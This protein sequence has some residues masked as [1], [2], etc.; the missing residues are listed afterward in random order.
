[1]IVTVGETTVVHILADTLGALEVERRTRNIRHNA[2]G[3]KHVVNGSVFRRVYLHNMILDIAAALALEVEI[4][5]VGEVEYRILV[6]D[7][8]VTNAQSVFQQRKADLDLYRSREMLLAVG[9]CQPERYRGL[10]SVINTLDSP[11]ALVVAE[12]AA[13]Q[14]VSI[15]VHGELVFC[16]VQREFRAA[17]S[18]CVTS[19]RCAVSRAALYVFLQ[20]IVAKNNVRSFAVPV[21]NKQRLYRRAEIGKGRAKTVF[22]FQSYKVTAVA[23]PITE[24]FTF[25]A[26]SFPPDIKY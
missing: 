13:V 12:L 11:Q 24:F 5:V 15:V 2:R 3:Y 9:T 20:R 4:R 1:M 14:G 19:D 16:A 26:H 18:V 22:V 8:I 17:Y 21:R 6:G 7:R 23:L 25:N 10:V